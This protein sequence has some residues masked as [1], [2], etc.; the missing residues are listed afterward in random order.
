MISTIRPGTAHAVLDGTCVVIRTTVGSGGVI[1][2]SVDERV[3]H[4]EERMADHSQL[5]VDLRQGLLQFEERVDRR[6]EHIEGR[7]T[8]LDQKVDGLRGDMGTHFHWTAGIMISGLIAIVAA[9]LA[10]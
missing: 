6:F 5:F 10:G 1:V 4:V 9:I 8:A 7:L 3:K 2:L